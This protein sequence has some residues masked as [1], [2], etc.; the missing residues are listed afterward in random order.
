MDT[1]SKVFYAIYN[2]RSSGMPKRLKNGEFAY[3]AYIYKQEIVSN[4][5][6]EEPRNKA[7]AI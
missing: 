6:T 5:P 4:A 2:G 1:G 7:S 3:A